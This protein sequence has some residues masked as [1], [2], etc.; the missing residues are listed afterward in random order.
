V[1][2]AQVIDTVDLYH[3]ASHPRKLSL[4][5][6]S[7]FLLKQDIQSGTSAFEGHDSIEDAYAALRLY[8]M[9]ESFEKDGRLADVME[10][11][12]DEGRRVVSPARVPLRLARS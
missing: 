6:L 3:S 5:F 10:D 9:Y 1:P 7:W 2:E 8:R 11:L 4:R 12:Y